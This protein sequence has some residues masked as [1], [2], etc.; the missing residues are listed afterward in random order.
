MRLGRVSFFE[1]KAK[2]Q[3]TRIKITNIIMV[4]QSFRL[5]KKVQGMKLCLCC[6][7]ILTN[8]KEKYLISK[9]FIED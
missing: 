9:N 3:V 6:F 4:Y 2:T 7:I 1:A 8:M 5:G